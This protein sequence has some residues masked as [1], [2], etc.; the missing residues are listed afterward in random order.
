MCNWN[1]AINTLPRK[2]K[3]KSY[4]PIRLLILVSNRL[5]QGRIKPFGLMLRTV[6]TS[7]ERFVYL[8]GKQ[9]WKNSENTDR[10]QHIEESRYGK[11]PKTQTVPSTL[12]FNVLGTVCVF[13]INLAWNKIFVPSKI[14]LVKKNDPLYCKYTICAIRKFTGYEFRRFFVSSSLDK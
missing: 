12:Q 14:N 2:N 4:L 9:I 10:A 11:T 13:Q 5:I 1:V 7:I 3:W 6:L 8:R